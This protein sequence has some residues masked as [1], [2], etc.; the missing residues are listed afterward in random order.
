MMQTVAG[1]AMPPRRCA[2]HRNQKCMRD[3]TVRLPAFRCN[4]SRKRYRRF[5][6]RIVVRGCATPGDK[7]SAS[8]T[9]EP[10]SAAVP[11][12][13]SPPG[14]TSPT[15]A[16]SGAANRS[17]WDF[18]DDGWGLPPKPPSEGD[19]KSQ[20]TAKKT[21][22][23][24]FAVLSKPP[25]LATL[26][27]SA[28]GLLLFSYGNLRNNRTE[29]K[30]RVAPK[31]AVRTLQIEEDS[32]VRE[33]KAHA[34]SLPS[35]SG[36]RLHDVSVTPSSAESP[37]LY[38]AADELEEDYSDLFQDEIEH[39]DVASQD[40][41]LARSATPAA[42]T[43]PESLPATDFVIS[44][45]PTQS[46]FD[47]TMD[48]PSIGD[49]EGH[50]S[51]E[52]GR[53]GS[54][55]DSDAPKAGT[56]SVGMKVGAAEVPDDSLHLTPSA[57]SRESPFTAYLAAEKERH[58]QLLAHEDEFHVYSLDNLKRLGVVDKSAPL[59]GVCK[60]R[61]FA[62]WLVRASQEPSLHKGSFARRIFT[63]SRDQTTPTAFVDVSVTDPDFPYIQGLAEAGVIPSR[64]IASGAGRLASSFRPNDPLTR[65]DLV[66]WKLTIDRRTLP[67]ASSQ[68]VYNMW[69]FADAGSI[70]QDTLDAIAADFCTAEACGANESTIASA[71][72]FTRLFHPRK[73]V[74]NGQVAAALS[75]WAPVNTLR[76]YSSYVR[77]PRK[78]FADEFKPTA[79]DA[80]SEMF[81]SE[82]TSAGHPSPE[83][84]RPTYSAAGNGNGAVPRS[85]LSTA[86]ES[87]PDYEGSA[88]ST[89]TSY[90]FPN[91]PTFN[92]VVPTQLS[93]EAQTS[94]YPAT[95]PLSGISQD[96][97]HKIKD[98][99]VNVDIPVTKEQLGH[100]AS[101]SAEKIKQAA[102]VA[103]DIGVRAARE[104]IRCA[105]YL[106]VKAKEIGVVVA[107]NSV[108]FV[109]DMRGNDTNGQIA[110]TSEV[111]GA[112][113]TDRS[114]ETHP[115]P[116]S[117]P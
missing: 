104:A 32:V 117:Q 12:D 89:Q 22:T 107:S 24:L 95:R 49:S 99:S 50:R 80:A 69:G 20:R 59:S 101:V 8:S 46:A 86:R 1:L 96:T 65:A 75:T 35:Q 81:P 106:L 3:D 43:A 67:A 16:T 92:P 115:K 105:G 103:K 10:S 27:A 47:N 13:P 6:P 108:K 68:V 62:R 61:D 100:A 87:T 33:G 94:S 76:S 64:M 25:V 97:F 57:S 52:D 30:L 34:S 84:Y 60:R 44:H 82:P 36:A 4:V 85:S 19:G 14:T 45:N 78:L 28:V 79:N 109:Q 102:L 90:S 40:E 58:G 111:N 7:P 29:E 110:S 15:T 55:I 51:S 21:K 17:G 71:F 26:G 83:K 88:P 42:V 113:V 31:P 116:P 112:I 74:Q 53:V 114:Q 72:G 91:T 18:E 39:T 11:P 5:Y 98:L 38:F 23:L 54:T 77:E 93:Q 37:A 66:T 48:E 70:H 73:V 63:A 41:A 56:P 9:P 2:R